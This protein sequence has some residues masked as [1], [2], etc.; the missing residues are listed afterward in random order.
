MQPYDRGP[1]FEQLSQRVTA[2]GGLFNA[3]LHLDRYATLNDRYMASAEHRILANSHVSL[4]KK[5]G[6]I[7]AL[8]A[9]PAWQGDDLANRVNACLDRM[10]A[11]GT[12]R[13]DTM[14]DVTDDE[15][16]LRG[17]DTL[18]QIKR[19]RAGQFDL[20]LAAYTPL[21]FRD[22]EPRR[23]ELFQEGA[24]LADFLGAL[25]EADDQADYP[26]HI[27]FMEHLRRMLELAQQLNMPVHVHTDQRNE[28]SETG[29]EQLVEAVRRFGA[30]PRIEGQ[31]S[32]W[33]VHMVSP[34]TYEEARFN[35]L[36]DGLLDCDIGV[37]CCPSAAIGMRQLRPLRSPTDNS[38]PRVLELISAGVPVCL[39]SDNIADICSPS[40]TPDLSDEV[41]VLSAAV[42]YYD[43]DVLA[44]LACGQAMPD[45]LRARVRDHLQNNAREIAKTLKAIG[46]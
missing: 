41:L 17:L 46:A 23:W 24:R 28:A 15:V 34:S 31:P 36:V 1:F 43:I 6:L 11:C 10:V 32:V 38:I 3:H 33:A 4:K 35:R 27:G 22:D 20:R 5:H 25:P 14:V 21:G 2:L 7:G 40:T 19:D 42:R 18:R 8:H 9:G 16:Q 29:T 12:R 26:S 13:G 39:G 37:I 30:P 45:A 44:H